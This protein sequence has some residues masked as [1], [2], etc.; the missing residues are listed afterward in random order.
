MFGLL[1]A[2]LA[3][4]CVP[5]I[6]TLPSWIPAGV[7]MLLAL[8]MIALR[9]A[10]P[11][12]PVWM[13]VVLGLLLGGAIFAQFHSLNGREAGGSLLLL[14]T[15]LKVFEVRAR[16]DLNLL[17][18][19]GYLLT[20]T[21]F[22]F[23]QSIPWV[24]YGLLL[25][26]G[27]TTLLS[28]LY[29]GPHP[30]SW[31]ALI[32]TNGF[33]L[34]IT[35]PLMLLLF[36]LFPRISGPLWGQT[37]NKS[38]VT[39]LSNELDPGSIARLVRSQAVAFRASFDN[40]TPPPAK[41]LYWRVRVM[42]RFNGS[43]WSVAHTS[44]AVQGQ[45]IPQTSPQHYTLLLQPSGRR[46]IPALDM[47]VDIPA[48]T[49]L[50]SVFTLSTRRP[51][52]RTREF[53]LAA[54]THYV[55]NPSLAPDVRRADLALPPGA[56]PKARAL[57]QRW[58]SE[59]PAPK[60]IVAQALRYFHDRPFYY[61]LKPP[62]LTGDPTD[63]FL[64][65]T[66]RGFCEHYA[67]AFAVLMRAAGIPARIITGYV[68]GEWNPVLHY[69]LVRQSDAHAWVEVWIAKHGW[70]RVDPT[71]AIAA[72]RVQGNIAASQGS[73]A[74]ADRGTLQR[75][76]GHLRMSWDSVQYIWGTWVVAFGPEQQRALLHRLGLSSD[77]LHMGLYLASGL[78][79]IGLLWWIAASLPRRRPRMDKASRLYRHHLHR[80]ANMGLRPSPSE[81][82]LDFAEHVAQ[83]LPDQ[84]DYA[85]NIAVLYT[86]ARYAAGDARQHEMRLKRLERALAHPPSRR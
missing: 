15:A 21:H 33:R 58:R 39:G 82:A 24:F 60:A 46:W 56:A 3:A 55:L 74:L 25:I 11:M 22:L 54:V 81:G 77:W 43:R 67:S 35:L 41:T 75:W 71:A 1:L 7:L 59:N 86:Q 68:G 37:Q 38:A 23:D 47:P 31:R 12:P 27:F 19:L 28:R 62:P 85:R 34:L 69:L 78:F 84:A 29:S 49:R 36:A 45:L 8:R 17:V 79:G 48:Q 73:T 72:N 83:R 80:L 10:W 2:L 57:A 40:S 70:V 52:E 76:L 4:T 14:G 30:P 42:T 16:R 6:G 26:L 64:F 63:D 18:Y 61:T 65:H 13:L 20:A 50:S 53:A 9:R 5:F 32:L 66:R 44:G 51:L